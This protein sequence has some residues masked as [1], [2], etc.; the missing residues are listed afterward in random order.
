MIRGLLQYLRKWLSPNWKRRHQ[1]I[2]NGDVW[3]TYDTKDAALNTAY[4]YAY[5]GRRVDI[6]ATWEG[7]E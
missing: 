3:H 1:V 5:S 7:S 6:D 4:L 2:V